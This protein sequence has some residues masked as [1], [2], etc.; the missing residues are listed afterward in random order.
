MIEIAPPNGGAHLLAEAGKSA[1]RMDGAIRTPSWLKG[2]RVNQVAEGSAAVKFRVATR[3]SVL[4]GRLGCT[5]SQ[6]GRR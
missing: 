6:K 2:S 5:P 3:S 4:K 1:D